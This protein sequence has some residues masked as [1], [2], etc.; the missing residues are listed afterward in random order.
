MIQEDKIG[1]YKITNKLNNKCYIG[2]SIN[3]ENRFEEHKKYK[4]H[5]S[6]YLH[7]SIK[8]YGEENFSFEIIELCKKED[9]STRE[10]YWIDFYN[11]IF[12]HGYNLT[13]G[14]DG[15][16][17]FKYR[18]TEQMK[19]TRKKISLATKGEKNGFYGK[20]HSEK[21]KENLR[22]INL[23][24]T[25]SKETKK[26]ISETLKDHFVS[27]LTKE[28]IRTATK[29]QWLN[30][31]YKNL[32]KTINL[33]N[34][35]AQGNT[36]N[37][38]R[39]DVYHKDTHEHKRIYIE[40]LE[41]FYA[42]GYIKGLPPTSK[43]FNPNIRH[44][45]SEHLVGVSFNKKNN[46]WIS[47]INFKKHRYGTKMFEKKEDAIQHR[48]YLEKILLKIKQSK[49]IDDID[50]TKSFEQGTIIKKVI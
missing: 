12:P 44:C 16:N 45:S 41:D 38:N 31:D 37:K 35:Y 27:D 5:S 19:E 50:I 8:K 1:I 21:T 3:I 39:I 11:S 22:Q 28:K 13:K 46:S 29:K 17:T 36:W 32:M 33:G 47:Y 10:I 14:G 6:R 40:Q 20:H 25:L 9:L 48:I 49:S 23:G 7:N 24:K 43:K 34:K 15:G 30:N 42:K 18:T 2:Q 4:S 26:K